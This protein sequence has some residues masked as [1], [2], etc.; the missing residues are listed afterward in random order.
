LRPVLTIVFTPFTASGHDGL[1]GSDRGSGGPVAVFVS[2]A[3]PDTGWA[4]WVAWQLKAEGHPVELDVW[5]WQ[6]GEDFVARMRAALERPAVVVLA[7]WSEAYF[8]AGRF[9][10]DE[11]SAVRVAAR[12]GAGRFVPLRVEDV[13]VPVLEGPLL[14]ADLFGVDP[15]TAKARLLAA[16]RGTAR[17]E[18]EPAFP[19][20]QAVTPGGP[21]LPGV[22]PPVWRVPRRNPAFTGRD[23]VLAGIRTALAGG[24]QMALQALHGMGGVGKTSLAIEYAHRFAADFEAVWWVD[25]EQPTLIAEQLRE[26]A[27]A[28][29]V[30]GADAD[31]R[32]GMDAALGWL[33][34]E[35]GWLVVF[36]NAEDPREAMDYLPQGRGQVLITSRDVRWGQAAGGVESVDVFARGESVGLLRTQLPAISDGEADKVAD[37]LGD[38]PLAVAQAAGFMA[39]S[40]ISPA[41]YLRELG[42][43]ANDVLKEGVPAGYPLPLAAAIGV[44][45]GRIAVLDPAAAELME[46]AAFLAPEPIPA[47]WFATAATAGV[48]PEAL[49]AVAGSPMALRRVL[50]LLARFGLLRLSARNDPILHRLTAAIVR[51]RLTALQRERMRSVAE[52]VL[53]AVDPGDT[54]SPNTWPAWTNLT[55]HLLA[56]DP[57]DSNNPDLRQLALDAAWAIISRGDFRSGRDLAARLHETWRRTLGDEASHT[58]IAATHLSWGC[59]QAGDYEAAR[60]LDEDV[61]A[62]ERRLLGEDHPDTLASAGGLAS[63]LRMLGE[64]VAARELDE[65]TL[66]RRRRVAGEDHP[67]TLSSAN[68]LAADLH[69]LGEVVAARELTEDTLARRRRVL[70]D[71]HPSTLTSA[72]NLAFELRALG[73]VVAARELDEQTLAVRRRVLGEEHP[74]TLT[75][76]NNLAVIERRMGDSSSQQGP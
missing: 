73:E 19:G 3:G 48:L 74:D 57:A 70:G 29:R 68:N 17:P 47:E 43:H 71:D 15:G 27:A 72:S 4:E 36:D 13:A 9:T 41:E 22:L 30:A 62:T 33:R 51:D 25:A 54:R 52:S 7:L 44:T 58:R 11:W 42:V 34:R 14:R 59:F 50:A 65:D 66:A 39:E 38:L 75:S 63:D 56:L 8:E 20:V 61:L 5:D 32:S 2:H 35:S 28:V 46:V 10:Q 40:G 67:D 64:V 16:V 31:V 24:G 55:P 76:M 1:M 23:G 6:V 53:I 45:L 49:A 26:L 12:K 21:R 60:R 37:E 18:V 69:T